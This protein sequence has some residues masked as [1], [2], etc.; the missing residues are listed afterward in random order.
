MEVVGGGGTNREEV[1]D[2]D[3]AVAWQPLKAQEPSSEKREEGE[4]MKVRH[5]GR[6]RA[7]A[8]EA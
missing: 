5:S 6:R 2:E 1:E 4:G 7:Y 3:E 8:D